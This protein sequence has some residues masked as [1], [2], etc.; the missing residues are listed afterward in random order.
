VSVF[1]RVGDDEREW[2]D[3]HKF[4]VA[5]RIRHKF[6]VARRIRG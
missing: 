5:R 3:F 6:A 2:D 1:R 4:A